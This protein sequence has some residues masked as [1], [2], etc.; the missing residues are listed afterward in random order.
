MVAWENLVR[1][2]AGRGKQTSFTFPFTPWTLLLNI[3]AGSAEKC[4]QRQLKR[5]YKHVEEMMKNVT[6]V[7][8]E[9]LLDSPGRES[10]IV[11]LQVGPN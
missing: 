8:N 4:E 9:S 2:I 1:M 10:T 5:Q 3:E 7:T 11:D 6:L